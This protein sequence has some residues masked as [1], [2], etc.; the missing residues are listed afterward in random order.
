MERIHFF[1]KP[2]GLIMVRVNHKDLPSGRFTYSTSQKVTADNWKDNTV[3]RDQ[4]TRWVAYYPRVRAYFQAIRETIDRHLVGRINPKKLIEELQALAKI[5]P[6]R[7]GF[8][9]VWKTIIETT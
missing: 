7:E 1:R 9:D 5:A 4:P 2:S 3:K 8:F 6:R